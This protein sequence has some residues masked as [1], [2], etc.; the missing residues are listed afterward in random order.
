MD[1]SHSET[2][3]ATITNEV[4]TAASCETTGV[5]TYTATAVFDGVEYTD[6]KTET[7]EALGHDWGEYVVTTAPTCTATGVETRTCSRCEVTETRPI[8]ALGHDL[9]HHEAQAPTCTAIGWEAYDTCSRC[10]YTT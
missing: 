10:D 2:V 6:T 9:V 1:A 5:K 3:T 7:L 8:E 4:T